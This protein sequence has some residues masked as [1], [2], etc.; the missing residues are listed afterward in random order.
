MF[1]TTIKILISMHIAG[2]MFNAIQMHKVFIALEKT[3]LQ[4]SKF[5]IFFL[6]MLI[7][8]RYV[9]IGTI[10]AIKDWNWL[11]KRIRKNESGYFELVTKTDIKESE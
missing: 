4:I 11:E 5:L 9:V 8:P 6:Y 2:A 1:Q 10:R 7:H 3:N